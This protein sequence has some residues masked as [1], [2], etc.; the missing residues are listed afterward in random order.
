MELKTFHTKIL[1]TK[2][3]DRG[4]HIG[5]YIITLIM[6]DRCLITA[7]KGYQKAYENK[8]VWRSTYMNSSFSYIYSYA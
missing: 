6:I 4:E 8:Q 7:A 1:N 3:K 2:I 5:R